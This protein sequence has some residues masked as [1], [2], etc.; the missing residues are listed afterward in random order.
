MRVGRLLNRPQE[1]WTNIPGQPTA[2]DLRVVQ[3][4][5]DDPRGT[6]VAIGPALQAQLPAILA[7]AGWGHQGLVWR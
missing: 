5:L 4:R 7:A 6:P 2:A 3:A 1:L